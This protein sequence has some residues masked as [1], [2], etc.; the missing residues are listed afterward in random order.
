MTEPSSKGGGDL[1]SNTDP[2]GE[3]C[4]SRPSKYGAVIATLFRLFFSRQFA[5]F[6]AVG[7]LNTAF[8]YTVFAV[9]TWV[10]IPSHLS[11]LIA[12][13]VGVLFNFLTTGRLVFSSKR[14]SFLPRFFGGYL[15]IYVVNLVL[16]DSL[17]GL[18]LSPYGGQALSLPVLVVLSF[19]VNKFLVFRRLA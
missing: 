6:V 14:W 18:G 11:L 9:L 10:S 3:H 7:V 8:G 12:T 19:V 17:M 2:R 16:L 4:G 1:C 15:A 5:H 13:I